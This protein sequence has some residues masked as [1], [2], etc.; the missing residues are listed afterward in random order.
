MIIGTHKK[1][2]KTLYSIFEKT[3]KNHVCV[4]LFTKKIIIKIQ[5]PKDEERKNKTKCIQ[6][7]I[8][9]FMNNFTQDL[10]FTELNDQF[11]CINMADFPKMKK[12]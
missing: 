11:C 8:Q 3:E 12:I 4:S 5:K 6:H 10:N 7:I 1:R 2:I 9:M